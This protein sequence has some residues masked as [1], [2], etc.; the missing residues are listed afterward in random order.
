MFQAERIHR[1]SNVWSFSELTSSKEGGEHA[2][3]EHRTENKGIWVVVLA[4]AYTCPVT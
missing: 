2:V 1:F 4:L 3:K